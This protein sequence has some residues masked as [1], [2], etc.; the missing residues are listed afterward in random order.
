MLALKTLPRGSRAVLS[1]ARANVAV[2]SLTRSLTTSAAAAATR[3][4]SASASLS[5]CMV[6]PVKQQQKMYASN[7]VRGLN[8]INTAVRSFSSEAAEEELPPREV[9][10]YDVLI[11]GA[12]P[13][14]LSAAI[15]L[16]QLAQEKG[17]ELSVCV[18]EKAAEVGGHVLSGNVFQPTYLNEL[19]PDWKEKG[20]PL[21][22]L[23]KDDAFQ[24]LTPT[25]AIPLPVLPAISNHG[26]YII[27]LSKL[28]R[29]LAQ[30]AEALGVEVYSGFAAAEILYGEAPA[31]AP[32]PVVGIATGDVGIGKDGKPTDSYARGMELRAKQTLF[33][34]G[35]RGSCSEEVI[36]KFNLREG[37]EPQS[38]G[39]GVKEVWEIK[40]ENHKEG[41]VTHTLGWPSQP[42]TYQG[43]FMYHA[44]NN[45]VYL[46]LVTGLD[47]ANPYI[48]PYHELQTFKT[49]PSVKKVLEGGKCIE[50]GARVINEGGYQSI[51]H[52]TFPGGALIGCSAGFVNVPKIKGSHNAM[53]SGMVAAE[54]I[55]D[56]ITRGQKAAAEGEDISE[57][58][59]KALAG[60]RV[61]DI[62]S[63]MDKS[64]VA[65]ELRQVRNVRPAFKVS[66]CTLYH[67]IPQRYV[68]LGNSVVVVV[69][70]SP[71][72][73]L[74][75]PPFPNFFCLSACS[76]ASSHSSSTPVSTCSSRASSRGR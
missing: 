39:L 57:I 54:G 66:H 67:V 62:Q 42:N 64:P 2:S 11:V 3:A 30:E 13:A 46:G 9:M 33:G 25:S 17:I 51:P 34:E 12:G 76:M 71:I 69:S 49:H 59:A 21:E 44:A 53:K 55:F 70:H 29:W 23:V 7:T 19:I 38:Y 58:L 68:L 27:S 61:T 18:V 75:L 50:Y 31:G 36:A 10:E 6:A 40:P 63:R 22:T 20:A 8:N 45:L 47:Y 28:T 65:E 56:A 48:S 43:T 60:Q 37:K 26:N 35:A 1:L 41:M 72:H 32:A 16:K 74:T 14:G 52:L 4:S 73:S 24:F 5:S 15:K